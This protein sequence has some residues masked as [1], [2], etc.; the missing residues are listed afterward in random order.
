MRYNSWPRLV[1]NALKRVGITVLPYYLFRRPLA[2]SSRELDDTGWQFRELTVDDVPALARLPMVHGNAEIFRE[3]L[4]NGQRSFALTRDG[5][6]FTFNWADPDACSY[7]GEN[8]TLA[9]DEIYLYD[10][11]TV[12]EQRGN[13]LAPLFSAHYSQQLA[14]RGYPYRRQHRR[15]AEP[16][17]TEL[18]AQGRGNPG[19]QESLSKNIR[20]FREIVCAAG[21]CVAGASAAT[22]IVLM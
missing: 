21:L 11:Y 16:A 3:R 5:E 8:F 17:V 10:I 18:L 6:I 13:N 4:L 20:R 19:S 9:D 22:R 12:P 15:R 2:E 1:I 14:G 7:P